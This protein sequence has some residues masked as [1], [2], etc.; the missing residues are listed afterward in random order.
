VLLCLVAIAV[1]GWLLVRGEVN[2]N[3]VTPNGPYPVTAGPGA[4]EAYPAWGAR[5]KQLVLL[6][7]AV[8]G[9]VLV[10]SWFP[11]VRGERP[12]L[13][14]G[15]VL[16]L[17]YGIGVVT[18]ACLLD[19]V[20]GVYAWDRY[21]IPAVPYL[22][23]VLVV[24]LARLAIPPLRAALA[25]VLG[26]WS[27]F[28]FHYVDLAA[29]QDGTTWQ[30][31]EKVAGMGYPAETIDGGLEW[32]GLHQP[33]AITQFPSSP[34]VRFWTALFPDPHICVVS[35]YPGA[36]FPVPPGVTPRVVAQLSQTSALGV[37]YTLVA[38]EVETGCRGDGTSRTRPSELPMT[39]HPLTNALTLFVAPPPFT[40]NGSFGEQ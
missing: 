24:P 33:T 13:S 6:L 21:L 27:I 14:S 39:P 1:A 26:A 3:Y 9:A 31:A 30:L 38:D 20:A 22:A 25:V 29:T 8:G 19:A 2:L 7:A 16:S 40:P 37:T 10:A 12:R 28:G 17:I 35:H 4:P 23:A 15:I 5:V 18:G 32:F 36:P 11:R 34:P